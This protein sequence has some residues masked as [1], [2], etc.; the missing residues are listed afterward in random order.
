MEDF[1]VEKLGD[2]ETVP[3][4][5]KPEKVA[6]EGIVDLMFFE[7]YRYPKCDDQLLVETEANWFHCG[8]A[9]R[10]RSALLASAY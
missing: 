1:F 4:G 7:L 8:A 9:V 10:S 5:L 2:S 3:E 6:V